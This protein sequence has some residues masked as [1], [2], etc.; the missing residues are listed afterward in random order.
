[1]THRLLRAA[2]IGALLSGSLSFGAIAAEDKKGDPVVAEVNG[3]AI[4][5]STLMETYQNSQ[6][7]QVPLEM[8]YDQVLDFVITGQILQGEAKKAGLE[9]DPK[10]IEAVKAAQNRIVQQAYLAKR[11]DE[12]VS[13]AAVKKRYDEL[14]KASAN[15]EE[16]KAS[17]ILVESEDKAKEIIARL[18][19][20]EDFDKL[21][22]SESI[23]PSA[24]EN[25]GD[26]GYFSEG[27]MVP[28]F[29]EAAFALKAGE[30][31]K[32][33]IKTQFGY[34]IIKL[35]DR[36][37]AEPPSF[38]DSEAAIKVELSQQVVQDVVEGLRAKATVKRF[39]IDGKPLK[40]DAAK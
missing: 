39:D 31:T 32:T 1:M 27:E 33:P 26:L 3:Q 23:D 11:I 24:K 2:V 19:K 10:V 17:H 13:G 30:M 28:E 16:V 5:R 29:S 37:K 12:A 35:V 22:R 15:R 21:A 4:H 14:V 38:A 8:V 7:R 34:H 20:G 25:G 18:E 6:F 40:D 9:K 36:R